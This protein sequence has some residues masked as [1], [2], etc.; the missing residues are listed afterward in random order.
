MIINRPYFPFDS[1]EVPGRIR[2]ASFNDQVLCDWNFKLEHDGE[3][4]SDPIV[5]PIYIVG[6]VQT[7]TYDKYTEVEEDGLGTT[8]TSIKRVQPVFAIITMA[9]EYMLRYFYE[10]MAKSLRHKIT[11]GGDNPIEIEIYDLDV[12]HET[13]APHV[14]RV[15]IT[16]RS[17]DE[18]SKAVGI[19]GCCTPLYDDAPYEEC[20]SDDPGSDPD[21]I[22]CSELDITV[23]RSGDDLIST[24]TGA[25][26]AYSVTWLYR[27]NSTAPWQSLIV[28]ASSISLGAPGIYRAVLNAAGCSQQFDQYLYQD[29]CAGIGVTAKIEGP[30]IVATAQGC[31]G[32]TYTF[33]LY[34]ED[35]EVWEDVVDHD[36]GNMYI[37][38]ETGLYKVIYECEEC[39][40]E[41]IIFFAYEEDCP[42]AILEIF[43]EEDTL[44]LEIDIENIDSFS[45][46]YDSGS[47][48][49]GVGSNSN[50]LEIDGNGLYVVTVTSGN[51]TYKKHIVINDECEEECDLEVSINANVTDGVGTLTGIVT[52][53][54]DLGDAEVDWHKNN[55][56]SG[57]VPYDSGTMDVPIDT[58]GLF[59]I[60]VKI[61]DCIAEAYYFNSICEECDEFDVAIT[62]ENDV[63]TAN[64][65]GCNDDP[66][67][68]WEF[69]NENGITDLPGGS[70][71]ITPTEQGLYRVTVQC[72]N[73]T[74]SAQIIA[75]EC[76]GCLNVFTPGDPNPI[77]VCT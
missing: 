58:N 38:D 61:G 76:D 20:P 13:V 77:T 29:P 59:R 65:S 34:D 25:P 14:H 39:T 32:G 48:L 36:M 12:E 40:A 43:R 41:A 5:S 42:E 44:T 33:Q 50:T 63:F 49:Q 54:L 9:D 8:H 16:Y 23:V 10:M 11:S 22:D 70:S 69:E 18:N 53:S 27:P 3:C 57:W 62:E 72:G 56:Q 46:E 17:D 64:V 4:L 30:A 35:S 37:P 1:P 31:Q 7:P 24:V 26:G 75:Y 74:A 55:G 71:S 21:P 67:F 52:T 47:G 66:I 28:G 2:Y 45:W 51:C 19:A 73:C 68:S 6:N 60:R 15:T